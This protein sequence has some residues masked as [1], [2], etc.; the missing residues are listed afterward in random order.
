MPKNLDEL[1]QQFAELLL[2]Q[3]AKSDVLVSNAV[4][5]IGILAIVHNG[6]YSPLLRA[7]RFTLLALFSD[8][9]SADLRARGLLKR[10][11]NLVEYPESSIHGFI[12]KLL[13]AQLDARAFSQTT[14]RYFNAPNEYGLPF[15]EADFASE[16]APISQLKKIINLLYHGEQAT[17]IIEQADLNNMRAEELNNAIEH[18]YQLTQ[19]AMYPDVDILATFG[20]ELHALTQFAELTKLV[21]HA[22][23]QI[24]ATFGPELHTLISSARQVFSVGSHYSNDAL[25]YLRKQKI[26]SMVAGA[27]GLVGA[28]VHSLRPDGHQIDYTFVTQFGAELPRY[29]MQMTE[30]LKNV[31]LSDDPERWNALAMQGEGLL[32][33][34]NTL[35]LSLP[36]LSKFYSLINIAYFGYGLSQEIISEMQHLNKASQER[37]RH[38]LSLFKYQ[39]VVKLCIEADKLEE[40]MLLAPGR[41][42]QP[43]LGYLQPLYASIYGIVAN[44]VD[45]SGARDLIVLQEDAFMRARAEQR[46]IRI[47]TRKANIEHY[48]HLLVISDQFFTILARHSESRFRQLS[49]AVKSQLEMQYK[50]IKPELDWIDKNSS[51]AIVRAFTEVPPAMVNGAACPVYADK[52][53]E[54]LELRPEFNQL[55]DKLKRTDEF[56]N[57]LT[58]D[59][60]AHDGQSVADAEFTVVNSTT[61]RLLVP[62]VRDL[63]AEQRTRY[64]IKNPVFYT[65]AQVLEREC[66]KFLEN[67]DPCI[68]NA[69]KPPV[70]PIYQQY[71]KV[72][73]SLLFEM[74]TNEPV[75]Y[76]E[77]HN[78]ATLIQQ[79]AV[80]LV[81]LKRLF[82][83][84][85]Y[86]KEASVQLELIA[87][88]GPAN[89]NSTTKWLFVARVIAVEENLR[90][91]ILAINYIVKD[92]YLR[93]IAQSL[94][95]VYQS[96]VNHAQLLKTPHTPKLAEPVLPVFYVFNSLFVLPKQLP[97]LNNQEALNALD[98][99]ADQQLATRLANDI[100]RILSKLDSRVLLFLEL[101]TCL[102]LWSHIKRRW[103]EFGR[104]LN[105]NAIQHLA[106]LYKDDIAAI[107]IEADQWEIKCGFKVGLISGPVEH[108]LGVYYREMIKPLVN[109]YAQYIALANSDQPLL[110]RLKVVEDMLTE[111]QQFL[112]GLDHD[113]S[114]LYGLKASTILRQQC[115]QNQANYLRDQVLKKPEQNEAVKYDYLQGALYQYA[116]RLYGPKARGFVLT[117]KAYQQG[118]NEYIKPHE[119][120]IVQSIQEHVPLAPQF[121]SQL[122]PIM[123]AFDQQQLPLYQKFEATQQALKQLSSY[124]KIQRQLLKHSGYQRLLYDGVLIEEQSSLDRKANRMDILEAICED[125]ALSIQDRL[126]RMQELVQQAEF[127]SDM[128]AHVHYDRFTFGW[129]VNCLVGLCTALGLFTPKRQAIYSTLQKS[130]FFA[131]APIVAPESVQ[132]PIPPPAEPR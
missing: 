10:Y 23:M 16:P 100:K 53:H 88:I 67:F 126:T 60:L 92:P 104:D 41:L 125:E 14:H 108:L 83:A 2:P 39:C 46:L 79:Q 7:A 107:L 55:I 118:L 89:E 45:F 33:A 35:R 6:H 38:L 22:E 114:D 57:Q 47:A 69:L 56:S 99:S 87:D 120:M 48:D 59:A 68:V 17:R 13:M 97:A 66:K 49:T 58:L 82:N 29:L 24:P 27:G 103:I 113:F 25:A 11:N 109:D 78:N 54:L 8:S 28:T 40:D 61:Q 123:H 73:S 34:I 62:L 127:K 90:H 70:L 19:L 77:A 52:I 101:P 75:P 50:L 116:E 30:Y 132:R 20:P 76:P 94:L 64:L 129:L 98:F 21:T 80:Q 51:T 71:K 43:L 115:L 31:P 117:R 96:C 124:I 85:H 37:L 26:D 9:N 119:E 111:D 95:N 86:L 63:I 131:S 84:V 122:A 4:P 128:L 12:R 72:A 42:A 121:A 65:K 102:N 93:E 32:N 110:K 18:L 5:Y 44:I 15:N 36:P 74:H 81:N 1:L 105:T 112:D 3:L 91:A 106:A 130:T